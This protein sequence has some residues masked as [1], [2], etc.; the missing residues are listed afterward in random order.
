MYT[1]HSLSLQY[2]Y[3]LFAV[4][5]YGYMRCKF[6][7]SYTVL[8]YPLPSSC[9]PAVIGIVYRANN[10]TALKELPHKATDSLG[11]PML[12]EQ[13]VSY[14]LKI[15]LEF[16]RTV[17]IKI[18]P[19]FKQFCIRIFACLLIFLHELGKSSRTVDLN[20]KAAVIN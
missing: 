10:K 17:R 3:E 14:V 18:H 4:I 12:Y 19:R 6:I 9:R 1:M 7:F 13:Y 11:L 8:F 15:I 20:G 2:V 5:L 16:N